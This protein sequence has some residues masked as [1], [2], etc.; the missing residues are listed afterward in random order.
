[1]TYYKH[2]MFFCTNFREDGSACCQ[3]YNAQVM[4]DYVKKRCKELGLTGDQGKIRINTA[5]CLNR[6]EEG[7]IIV[8]YPDDVWYTYIDQED[9]DEIIE[10]HLLNSR[11]VKR[12]QI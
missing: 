1:M 2:H 3:K 7:P 6:C 11:E 5:G 4:R 9:L 10:E 8:V 12:L